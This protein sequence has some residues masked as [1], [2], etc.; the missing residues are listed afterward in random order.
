[1]THCGA[2]RPTPALAVPDQ[3][4]VTGGEVDPVALGELERGLVQADSL[5]AAGAAIGRRALA[6]VEVPAH[7]A[8]EKLAIGRKRGP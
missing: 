3:A 1:L 2:G 8:G 7:F 6:L 4:I 5:A